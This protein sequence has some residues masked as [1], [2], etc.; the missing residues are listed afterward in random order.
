MLRP[1]DMMVKAPQALSSTEWLTWCPGTACQLL[2]QRRQSF[3]IEVDAVAG[4]HRRQG[5]ALLEDERMFDIAIE[6]ET[7]RLEI[8]AIWAGR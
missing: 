3:P 1:C 8:G 2:H 5:H 4:P 6:P 7:V